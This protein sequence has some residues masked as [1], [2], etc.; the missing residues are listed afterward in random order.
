[1]HAAPGFSKSGRLDYHADSA[2]RCGFDST[3]SVFIVFNKFR[4]L[5]VGFC[6]PWVN[7]LLTAMHL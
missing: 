4:L 6:K 7:C 1:M 2:A 3:S 5:P